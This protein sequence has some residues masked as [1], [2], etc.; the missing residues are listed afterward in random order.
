MAELKEMGALWART[1]KS[2]N[3]FLSGRIKIGGQDIEIICFMNQKK[4]AK[5]PD[6]KIYLSTPKTQSAP[7]RPTMTQEDIPF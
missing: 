6:W 7:I 5:H 1:S 4:D 2:G 3:E